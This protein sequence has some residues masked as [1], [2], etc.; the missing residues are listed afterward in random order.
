MSLLEE[1]SCCVSHGCEFMSLPLGV[2]RQAFHP[3]V[4]RLRQRR[5]RV[6]RRKRDCTPPA[7]SYSRGGLL[8]RLRGLRRRKD[9]HLSLPPHTAGEYFGGGGTGPPPHNVRKYLGGGRSGLPP[10]T[11]GVYFMRM[12][13]DNDEPNILY[14]LTYRAVTVKGDQQIVTSAVRQSDESWSTSCKL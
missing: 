14:S 13:E 2:E 3:Q 7:S 1:S 9:W 6:L 10:H 11:V 12:V 8:R 4:R 5:P